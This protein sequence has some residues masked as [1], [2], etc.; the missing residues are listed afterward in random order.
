MA[1]MIIQRRAGQCPKRRQAFREGGGT[2]GPS[3]EGIGATSANDS[4]PHRPDIRHFV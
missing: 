4:L 1:H 2:P 3:Q